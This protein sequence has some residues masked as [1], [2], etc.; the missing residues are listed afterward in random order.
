MEAVLDVHISEM[1]VAV[2][3][4]HI[5]KSCKTDYSVFSLCEWG[6]VIRHR[7]DTKQGEKM[8]HCHIGKRRGQDYHWAMDKQDTFSNQR[9]HVVLWHQRDWI[10]HIKMLV[11]PFFVPWI[12]SCEQVRYQACV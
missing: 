12:I 6:G 1:T 5:K 8:A 11:G 9:E 7:A 10:T 2:Y 3:A 4:Y